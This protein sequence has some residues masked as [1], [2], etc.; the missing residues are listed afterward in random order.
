M[1]MVIDVEFILCN[2][3]ICVNIQ[4]DDGDSRDRICVQICVQIK[5][6]NVCNVQ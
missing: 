1:I 6:D 4:N 5:N 2:D 3:R